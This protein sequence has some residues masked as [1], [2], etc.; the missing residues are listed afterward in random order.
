VLHELGPQVWKE[1]GTFLRQLNGHAHKVSCLAVGAD[2]ILYSGSWDQRINVWGVDGALLATLDAH[3]TAVCSL[4]V[5]R[6][7]NRLYSAYVFF[8]FLFFLVVFLGEC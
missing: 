4:A 1:D 2:G 6:N 8:F 7:S 3:D 5:D